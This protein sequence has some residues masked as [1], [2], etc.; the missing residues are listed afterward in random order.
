MNWLWT[1]H[2]VMFEMP[3]N[4]SL[5]DCGSKGF[6]AI[7]DGLDLRIGGRLPRLPA[8]CPRSTATKQDIRS[9]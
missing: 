4:R 7:N 9:G 3:P 5:R 6:A 8:S 1:L 2:A